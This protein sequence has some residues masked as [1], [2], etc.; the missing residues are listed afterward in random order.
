MEP[1]ST[2]PGCTGCK[3]RKETLDEALASYACQGCR[4]Y[5]R[6]APQDEQEDLQRGTL[7]P[8]K[9][10]VGGSHYKDLKI[11]PIEIS[12]AN[13]LNPCQTHA[14]KYLIR[15]KGGK[16]K[17]IEDRRKAIHMI[18]LEIDYLERGELT[19]G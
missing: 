14:I 7:G 1:V 9:A 18:Q 10:Q 6:W 2:A 3:H 4:E 8:T 12:V 13:K 17:V 5:D 15:T 11:Q 16:E 19:V